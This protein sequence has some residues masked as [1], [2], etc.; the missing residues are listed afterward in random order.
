MSGAVPMIFTTKKNRFSLQSCP[1]K[2]GTMES[3]RLLWLDLGKMR[4]EKSWP[5]SLI[6]SCARLDQTAL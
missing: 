2:K 1:D 5:D 3:F 4:L 6:Q